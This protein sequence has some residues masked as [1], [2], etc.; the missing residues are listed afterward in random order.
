MSPGLARQTG[1]GTPPVAAF[2]RE[3]RRSPLRPY[4]VLASSDAGTEKSLR[5]AETCMR[6]GWRYGRHATVSLHPPVAWSAEGR[7]NRSLEFNLHAWEGLAPVLAAHGRT[8]SREHLEFA[9]AM[10]EDW[11]TSHTNLEHDAAF[12]WYDMA[13]GLRAYRLGYVLD[14]AARSNET[15]DGTVATLLA[16]AELHL[17]VLEDDQRFASHSNHGFFFTAGQLALARRFPRLAGATAALDQ[18]HRRMRQ[19]LDTQFTD[20]GVHVEHSPDYHRMVLD[21][22]LGLMA[23]G[24]LDADDLEERSDRIQ[25]ALAWFLMPDG[26]IAPVGDSPK[27]RMP[28]GAPSKYTNAALRHALTFGA[29]GRTPS[30]T[31]RAFTTAGYAIVRD[32]WPT[33]HVGEARSY[34][35]QT[36]AFHSRVHK[37]ADDL[38]FV[39]FDRGQEL[40]TDSGRYGYLGRTEPGSG[41]W[42]DGFWY[43]D[44]AR[45]YVEST[46]AHNT[47]EID[48]RNLPRRDVRPYGSALKGT[49]RQAGVHYTLCRVMHWTTVEHTRALLYRPGEWLV[50]LDRVRDSRDTSHSI[51]QRFQFAPELQMVGIEGERGL[52]MR[53]SENGLGLKVLTLSGAELVPPVRGR[54][55]PE[56][57]GW[58]SRAD[59]SLQSCW[60]AGFRSVGADVVIATILSL[61]TDQPTRPDSH[62]DRAGGVTLGWQTGQA[63][64][65]LAVDGLD[66]D[67]LALSYVLSCPVPN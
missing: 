60:T 3:C 18:G 67:S 57:L 58:V 31:A 13:I 44:P 34:L 4:E 22:F 66:E 47:V 36:C 10:A 32:A 43:A 59:E 7:D 33:G 50:V 48:G 56:L 42:E 30:E 53:S 29:K 49:G 23:A 52:Q 8:G 63:A 19:L 45:V 5:L 39:W 28:R 54:K 55:D 2:R 14:I 26:T 37:Q 20:D 64:H 38:S 61:G 24:L 12:A 35:L 1:S 51:V 6:E 46:R 16:S 41:P 21:T 25:E 40:L 27:R 62:F 11:A 15:S 65:T 9:V 17:T